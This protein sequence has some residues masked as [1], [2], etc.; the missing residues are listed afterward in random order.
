MVNLIISLLE[1][2][3][4]FIRRL[5]YR[6]RTNLHG[7]AAKSDPLSSIWDYISSLHK[8]SMIF[9]NFRYNLQDYDY[10][11]VWC[12]RTWQLYSAGGG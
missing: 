2:F 4:P 6:P 9:Y 11:Q 1:L 12:T 8:D 10:D 5:S 7:A 3:V